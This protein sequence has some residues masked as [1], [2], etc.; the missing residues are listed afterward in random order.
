MKKISLTFVVFAFLLAPVAAEPVDFG[1]SL[2]HPLSFDGW[3]HGPKP[4]NGWTI[5]GGGFCGTAGGVELLSGFSFDCCEIRLKWTI[6]DNGSKLQVRMP[7]VPTGKGLTLTLCEGEGCGRLTDGDNVLSPGVSFHPVR[8]EV[9]PNTLILRRADGKISV[10]VNDRTL[11][12]LS[13]DTTRRF[14]L[15]LAVETGKVVVSD[16]RGE[17]PLDQSLSNGKDLTGWREDRPNKWVVKNGDLVLKPGQAGWIR[18]IKDYENFTISFDYKIKKGGNSGL[19][20]RTPRIGWPSNDGMEM[21]IID[22][23]N[24]TSIEKDSLM[25]CYCNVPPFCRADKPNTEAW[26]HVV[27]KTD[28][29]MVSAWVDGHLVQQFNTRFHPELRYR[30]LRGWLG[31]QDHGRWVRF[32]NIKLREAPNGEGLKAWYAHPESNGAALLVDRLMNSE[33]LAIDHQLRSGVVSTH[34]DSDAQEEN[35]QEEDI[36]TTVPSQDDLI[37]ADLK[38]PGVLTRIV[39]PKETEGE[40]AFYF[41][42]EQKPRITCKPSELH[43]KLPKINHTGSPLTAML[44]YEKALKIVAQG[45]PQIDSRIEYVTMPKEHPVRSFVS[46]SQEETGIP[47][48]WRVPTVFRSSRIK[49]GTYHAHDPAKTVRTPEKIIYAGKSKPFIHFDGAGTVKYIMLLGD[50]SLLQSDD[51]WIEV[52]V[53]R[54][55]KPAISAPARFWLPAFVKQNGFYNFVFRDFYGRASH[56]GI[57]FGDGITISLV[58]RGKRKIRGVGLEASV[59]AD[60]TNPHG[61]PVGPMRLRA[62]Y[63]PAGQESDVL[64]EKQGKGRF[65][66]IVVD[67]PEGATPGISQLEV[68]SKSVAGWASP[69]LSSLLGSKETSFADM[70]SGNRDGMAWRYFLLA[71]V[72]FQ[73]SIQVQSTTNVLPSRLILYYLDGK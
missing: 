50:R 72:D 16:I 9:L 48:G 62:Q 22:R 59:V 7:E 29:W 12:T 66:G 52:T 68:D 73:K 30:Q 11:Y 56:L 27:I 70:T 5:Q 40:L 44:C 36:E 8:N 38:G 21:Q 41:D 15:A 47:R 60:A 37:L 2:M 33:F 65:V 4:I 28:G 63:I 61:Q 57:P 3:N 43:K 45:C 69:D 26:N 64:L 42:G 31:F 18:T 67:A 1:L 25:S 20:I 24:P 10:K 23:R 39:L 49:K 17:E 58:N 71:P 51:L 46:T 53:D 34:I 14:G 32:R 13:L 19:A 35:L 54:E 6:L 55:S